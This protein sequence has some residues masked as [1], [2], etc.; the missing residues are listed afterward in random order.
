MFVGE[1]WRVNY[2]AGVLIDKSLFMITKIIKTIKL[3]K[4]P[5]NTLFKLFVAAIKYSHK[6]KLVPP[7]K[8][9]KISAN[10]GIVIS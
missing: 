4:V 10:F 3:I 9:V 6:R 1:D 5:T 7:E 2:L 8:Q